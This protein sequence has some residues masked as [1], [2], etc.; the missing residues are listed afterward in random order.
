MPPRFLRVAFV[1]ILALPLWLSAATALTLLDE[2]P[3]DNPDEEETIVF[4]VDDYEVISNIY[5]FLTSGGEKEYQILISLNYNGSGG[6]VPPLPCSLDHLY[7]S[8][9]AEAISEDIIAYPGESGAPSTIEIQIGISADGL[10]PPPLA[11]NI[12]IWIANYD[13]QAGDEP[14]ELDIEFSHYDLLHPLGLF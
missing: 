10:L 6:G 3:S 4:N 13:V 5:V 11:G 14:G 7:R 12:F 1:S 8:A 2:F 9:I